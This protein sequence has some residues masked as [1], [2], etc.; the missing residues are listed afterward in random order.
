MKARDVM[1]TSVISVGP[2]LG[3]DK[4]AK[5]LLDKRISGVPVVDGDGKPIGMVS[6]GDLI[7]RDDSEEEVR[8][9]W[10]LRLLAE[11]EFLNP[12]FLASLQRPDHKVRDIMASPA[13]SVDEETEVGEIARLLIVHRIKRVPVVCNERVVGIVSRADLLRTIADTLQPTLEGGGTRPS[14]AVSS[15]ARR[16]FPALRPTKEPEGTIP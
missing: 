11:G 9:D 8:R 4:L 7:G 15:G 5:L 14:M 12:Q 6:E 3:I 1:T 10:W 2:D 16:G 13:I